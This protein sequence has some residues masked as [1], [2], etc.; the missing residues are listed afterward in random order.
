MSQSFLSTIAHF[1]GTSLLKQHH[2]FTTPSGSS[3]MHVFLILP[4]LHFALSE[5]QPSTQ[6]LTA[7][8]QASNTPARILGPIADSAFAG[9]RSN[10]LDTANPRTGD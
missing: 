4:L 9:S 2:S 10:L 3:T 6:G 1:P 8:H 7:S 5:S